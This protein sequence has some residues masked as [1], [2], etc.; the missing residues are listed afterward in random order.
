[1]T[2]SIQSGLTTYSIYQCYSHITTIILS[3]QRSYNLLYIPVLLSYNHYHSIQSQVLQPTLYTSAAVTQPLSFY[4]IR[5]LTTY[6][7]YQCCSHTTSIIL[8]NQR[9]YNPLY[10]SVLQSHNLYHSIQSEVLQP[11]LHA[12]AAVTQPLSFYPIRGLTTYSTCQCRPHTTTIILSNQRSYNLLYI[13]VLPLH[14]HYCHSI[15][16]GVLQSTLHITQPLYHSIQSE[17]L[18]NLLYMLVVT[19]HNHYYHSIQ[20]SNHKPY[21]L[22]YMHV[23]PLHNHYCHSI[24]SETIQPAL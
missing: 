22:I 13:P 5:G 9:S 4:P 14:K 7:I 24:Q 20:L 15:Q 21:N 17:V 6:S 19:S 2:S 23:L 3:N 10:M 8:S 18:K 16:P 11:T 12:S 1:M